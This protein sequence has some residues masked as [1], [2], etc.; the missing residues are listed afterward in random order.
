MALHKDAQGS[1]YSRVL[2]HALY[3]AAPSDTSHACHTLHT[4]THPTRDMYVSATTLNSVI[5][6]ALSV[7]GCH[8]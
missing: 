3:V 6:Y 8:C 4:P 7:H 1:G 5:C 2:F